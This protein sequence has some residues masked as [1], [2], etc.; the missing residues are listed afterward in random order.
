[1]SLPRR[2]LLCI[3]W[4]LVLSCLC[5]ESL[6]EEQVKWTPND[7]DDS[8]PLPLSMKQR[9]KLLQLEQAIA[10]SPDPQSTLQQVAQ[11]NQMNP[12]DLVNMLQR[13][14]ADLQS[15]AGGPIMAGGRRNVLVQLLSS[16]TVALMQMARRHPQTFGLCS[17][18]LFLV[19]YVSW[20]APRSGLCLSTGPRKFGW[21]NGATTVWRPPAD[22]VQRQFLER[23]GL[24][25]KHRLSG[26]KHVQDVE[27]LWAQLNDSATKKYQWLNRKTLQQASAS[28]VQHAAV[29]QVTLDLADLLDIVDERNVAN[30]S[31]DHA[32]ELLHERQVTEFSETLRYFGDRQKGVLVVPGMGDWRRV[33]LLPVWVSKEASEDATSTMLVLNTLPGYHW[34]GEIHISALLQ[35]DD[36]LILRVA[37]VIPKKKRSI[38]GSVAEAIVSSLLDSLAKS[39][40]TRTRQ[41]LSR[42]KQSSELRRRAHERAGKRRQTRQDKERE[43][44]EMAADRRRRWQRQNPNAGHYRPSGDRMRSPNNAIYH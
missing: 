18:S 40:T 29:G 19:L 37:L 9:Q 38:S 7:Q 22:F 44:E 39:V 36:Q 11:A 24:W 31:L 33:G 16:I 6:A 13:N 3:V 8:G 4:F 30:L 21:T 15:S 41:S 23:D 26:A 10:S 42:S 27:S 2:P 34:D 1:M 17:L 12:Q 32:R 35:S 14:R 25:P 20:S 28:E 43:L 5:Q